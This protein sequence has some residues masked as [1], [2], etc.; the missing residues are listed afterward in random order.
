MATDASY[1]DFVVDQAGPRLR[2]RV[3]RMFGEY[4]LYVDEKVVGFL[5][6][7]RVLLKPTD[8]GRAFFETPEIGRPY[9]GAK[10]YWIADDAVE[11]APR[12]QD[13]LRATAN[14]LPAPKPKRR[15]APRE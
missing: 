10:D 2:V 6:D 14:E 7:N 11:E 1:A 9:P 15:K 4:A 13:L 5:C 3:G 12:F 8:A